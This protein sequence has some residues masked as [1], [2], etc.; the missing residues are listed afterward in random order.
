MVFI[1]GRPLWVLGSLGSVVKNPLASA[2]D[3]GLIPGSGRL[4]REGNGDPLQYSFLENPMHRGTLQATVHGIAE[5][6]TTEQL[7]NLGCVS[8][9]AGYVRGL[10][11]RLPL[12]RDTGATLAVETLVKGVMAT[13]LHD[14]PVCLKHL[15]GGR[16][17]VCGWAAALPPF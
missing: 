8:P 17:R 10:T 7:N 5:S 16:G 14:Q 9:R 11:R 13:W 4:P 3:T 12:L 1:C 6:D 2:G 15:R